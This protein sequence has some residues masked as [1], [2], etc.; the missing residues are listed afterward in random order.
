MLQMTFL[1]PISKGSY[2]TKFNC[3]TPDVK[4]KFSPAHYQG[5]LIHSNFSAWLQILHTT[6]LLPISKNGVLQI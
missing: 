2:P 4:H 3:M 6:F 1:L 5:G